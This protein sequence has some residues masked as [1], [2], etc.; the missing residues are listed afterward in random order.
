M[1]MRDTAPWRPLAVAALMGC[2][3]F[4]PAGNATPEGPKLGKPLNAADSAALDINVFPDG[5]GL[6]R[7]KGTA[8]EGK[9]IYDAQCAA[10]HGPKGSGGSAGELAGGSA[11]NGPHPDQTVGNYWPY[12]TTIFDFVRRSMPL[13]APRSLSDEQVY[14]ITAYLLHINGLIGETAEI[15]AKTLPE[16]RM[17][18]RDGFVG[19]WPNSQ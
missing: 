9:A 4:I 6:P 2:L 11:L 3:T 13:N 16:V 14:A 10:C 17:P 1:S 5:S 12:A 19:I 18:N 7:G 8:V 15:N